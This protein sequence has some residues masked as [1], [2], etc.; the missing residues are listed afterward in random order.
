MN[1]KLIVID[2]QDRTGKDTLLNDIIKN[3]PENYIIYYQTTCDDAKVDYRD[4]VAFT[5]HQKKLIEK[6]FN[7][8]KKLKEEN[9]NKNIVCMRLWISDEVYSDMFDREHVTIQYKEEFEKIFGKENILYFV[10]LW[11]SFNDFVSRMQNI[12]DNHGLNEY[13]EEEFQKVKKLFV[14]Y[15]EKYSTKIYYIENETSQRQLFNYI[16]TYLHDE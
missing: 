10:F 8:I 15:S 3:H 12:K 1:N 13:S 7:D 16:N 4:K 9:P 14:K 11:K 5:K 2:G 6:V